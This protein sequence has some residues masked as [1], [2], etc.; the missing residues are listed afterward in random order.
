MPFDWFRSDWNRTICF[1]AGREGRQHMLGPGW[2]GDESSWTWTH[3]TIARLAFRLPEPECETFL[4]MDCA[5]FTDPGHGLERQSVEIALNGCRLPTGNT[6]ISDRTVLLFSIDRD[7]FQRN[8]LSVVSLI[9]PDAKSPASLHPENH[10]VRRLGVRMRGLQWADIWY[11]YQ[12]GQR[13]F[14]NSSFPANRYFLYGWSNPEPD[15][16]WTDGPTALMVLRL[17][18]ETGP[19]TFQGRIRIFWPGPDLPPLVISVFANGQFAEKVAITTGEVCWI[20]IPLPPN[21]L[22]KDGLLYLRFQIQPPRS[23]RDFGSDDDRQLGFGLSE[24]FWSHPP[25]K[26]GHFRFRL[27]GRECRPSAVRGVGLGG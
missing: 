19:L 23:P 26:P 24:F 13:I 4:A 14:T 10:D 1:G 9:L 21:C 27:D 6:S 15:F 2:C 22:R 5:P 11:D 7:T 8:P 18:G 16:C 12:P 17:R 3:G 25:R 20:E